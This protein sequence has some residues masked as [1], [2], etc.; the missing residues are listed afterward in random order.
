[1]KRVGLAL[2][3]ALTIWGGAD[4]ARGDWTEDWN[5]FWTRCELDYHRNAHWPK[6]F[7]YPDRDAY[8]APFATMVAKGWQRQ[9]T[10]GDYHFDR[11]THHLNSAGKAQVRWIATQTPPDRRTVFVYRGPNSEVTSIRLDSVQRHMVN[12]V[13]EG[14]LPAVV[15]VG[16]PPLQ[17]P[18]EHIDHI[19]N[20]VISGMPDPVLPPFQ[21]AGSGG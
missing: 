17:R 13:A 19:Q 7:I 9:N 2:A 16:T 12:S 20:R 5:N 21:A 4:S 10:L 15:D 14:E 8:H 6:P 11:N 3:A 1:M 18:G